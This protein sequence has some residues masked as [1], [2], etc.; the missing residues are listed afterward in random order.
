MCTVHVTFMYMYVI[1]HDVLYMIH[2]TLYTCYDGCY[3]YM[4]MYMYVLFCVE[5]RYM[6]VC[7]YHDASAWFLLN[8]TTCTCLCV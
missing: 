7:V 1:Q 8:V 3:M 6:Y 4:Y 5:I 2:Y